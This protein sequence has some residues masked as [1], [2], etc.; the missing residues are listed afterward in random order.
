MPSFTL[1]PFSGEF[2]AINKLEIGSVIGSGTP[3]SVVFIDAAGALGQDN[4]NFFWDDTSDLLLLGGTTAAT[5]DIVL[6]A[7]GSAVYNEQAADVDSRREGTT[8]E[9]LQYFDAGNNHVIIGGTAGDGKLS[10]IGTANEDTLYLRLTAGQSTGQAIKVED[11]NETAIFLLNPNGG[12]D[13]NAAANNADTTIRGNA[14]VFMLF[15][16]SQGQIGV[17]K[18]LNLAATFDINGSLATPVRTETANYTATINDYSIRCDTGAGDVTITL[19]TAVGITGRWYA[20]KKVTTDN[21]RMIIDPAGAE[22]IDGETDFT[23]RQDYTAIMIQ[24]NGTNWDIY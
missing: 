10:V 3:G 13:I 7:D 8:D 20:I 1:N 23:T 12:M 22:T 9:N 5:A 24:S 19:P 11:S 6:G 2:D 17:K 14:E 16:A 15:D 18:T 4:A 21:N